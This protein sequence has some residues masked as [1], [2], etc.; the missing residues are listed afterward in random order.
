MEKRFQ[1]FIFWPYATCYRKEALSVRNSP[2][3]TGSNDISINI[4]FSDLTDGIAPWKSQLRSTCPKRNLIKQK[5]NVI[6]TS[7]RGFRVEF[8]VP[9]L[10][11]RIRVPERTRVSMRTRCAEKEGKKTLHISFANKNH[12]SD[13]N[14]L[15][16]NSSRWHARIIMNRGTYRANMKKKKNSMKRRTTKRESLF[17]RLSDTLDLAPCAASRRVCASTRY[18][19]EIPLLLFHDDNG[20]VRAFKNSRIFRIFMK[21]CETA[22]R[23]ENRAGG[24]VNLIL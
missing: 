6:S 2:F 18:T 12:D 11:A 5:K 16:W 24:G 7:V 20:T 21:T 3:S 4:N 9:C 22:C 8:F 23:R 15:K 14:L 19:R 1:N 13:A 10:S 17:I